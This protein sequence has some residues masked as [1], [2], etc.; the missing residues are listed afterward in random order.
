M[1]DVSVS[2]AR[3]TLRHWRRPCAPCLL[4]GLPFAVA[5][6]LD[7]GAVDQKV[8]GARGATVRDL[9]GQ[10]LLPSAEGRVIGRGPVQLR[11]PKQAGYHPGCLPQGQLEQHL[12]RQAELDGGVGEH[13]RATEAPDMRGEPRHLPVQPD[14]Q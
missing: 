7:A 14:Q 6:E 8:Q 10:G 13:R 5:E 1:S 2:I 12:D 11:H 4:A 9:D 3:C